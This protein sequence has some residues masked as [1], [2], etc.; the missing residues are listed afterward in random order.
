MQRDGSTRAPCRSRNNRIPQGELCNLNS[1]LIEFS[2]N[3]ITLQ[4]RS[5]LA[6]TVRHAEV[7]D[8]A[9]ISLPRSRIVFSIER[10][11]VSF[12]IGTPFVASITNDYHDSPLVNVTVGCFPFFAGSM[13][14]RC[15]AQ[16]EIR[17]TTRQNLQFNRS[18]RHCLFRRFFPLSF[19]SFPLIL[20][21]T[22]VAV[23]CGR[24]KG[25]SPFN[26]VEFTFCH[27]YLRRALDRSSASRR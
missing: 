23:E 2:I 5:L 16:N 20:R 21:D 14:W 3:T 7:A 12:V 9:T 27:C 10:E 26:F 4:S 11:I 1:P 19:P 8:C 13:P 25:R 17:S 6:R 15:F 24:R 22:Q 18:A